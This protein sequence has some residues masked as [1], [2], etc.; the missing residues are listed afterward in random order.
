[1]Y[2]LAIISLA[3]FAT[4]ASASATT[5]APR[6][7]HILTTVGQ[8]GGFDSGDFPSQCT[9]DCK[10][11]ADTAS[12]DT[13]DVGCVCNENVNKGSQSC[14]DCAIRV[15]NG[16]LS[17][18]DI[19]GFQSEMKDFEDSCKQAGKALA[20]LTI[21]SDGV[22][23]TGKSAAGSGYTLSLASLGGI[24]GAAGVLLL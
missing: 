5:H 4:H 14:I 19:D 24:L 13:T 17:Q 22:L 2:P 12:C 8:L 15:A 18:S 11:L 20:S 16:T 10:A 9:S 1:M 23:E 3:L 21:S 6:F 7:T